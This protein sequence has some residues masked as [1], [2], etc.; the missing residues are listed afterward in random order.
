MGWLRIFII[1]LEIYFINVVWPIPWRPQLFLFIFRWTNIRIPGKSSSLH[2]YNKIYSK[3]P[4]FGKFVSLTWIIMCA[5]LLYQVT[6]VWIISFHHHECIIIR[7]IILAII[8]TC[9]AYAMSSW[10]SHGKYTAKYKSIFQLILKCEVSMGNPE[11]RRM[12]WSNSRCYIQLPSHLLT[13]D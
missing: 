13:L 2:N 4:L 8:F 12:N 7:E 10:Y 11:E 3:S 6:I 1:Y 5:R 9:L